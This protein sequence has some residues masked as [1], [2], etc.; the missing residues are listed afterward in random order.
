MATHEMYFL[1]YVV[2]AGVVFFAA[3]IYAGHTAKRD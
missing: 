2:A 3:L 1:A